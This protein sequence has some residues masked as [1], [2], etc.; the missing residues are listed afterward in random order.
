MLGA[1]IMEML[2]TGGREAL[3]RIHSHPVHSF[4]DAC[5]LSTAPYITIP[6]EYP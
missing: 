6:R 3:C 2:E 1:N 4:S 5:H